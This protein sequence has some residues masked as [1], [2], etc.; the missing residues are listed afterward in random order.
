MMGLIGKKIG[1]TQVFK[2]DGTCIPVT[3]I[4]VG[5]CTVVEKKNKDKHG[6]DAV[7]IGFE[8]VKES[9]LTKPQLGVFE[10]LKEELK[11]NNSDKEVS[12]KKFLRE[13]KISSK[14]VESYDLGQD[15][16]VD[17]FEEIK[18][19]DI[20]GK[21]KG[22]G[23][24]GVIKRYNQ[25]RGRMTHGSKFHREPGSI[26]QCEFPGKVFKNT[27]MPGQMGTNKIT[28][29]NLEVV[30]IMKEDNVL[31]VKGSVPGGKNQL[32]LIKK[33]KKKN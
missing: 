9:K 23:F 17:M 18:Y 20:S 28:V 14:D 4:K 29:Q 16:T 12:A 25:G 13:F 24:Q 6:Y 27:K 11:E 21:T 2:D 8:D 3:A 10:K 7:K 15:L 5:P 32:L 22:K 30:Q 31:L 1:M 19:V 33:S 26:G